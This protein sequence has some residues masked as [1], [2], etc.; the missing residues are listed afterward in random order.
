[1]R[2]ISQIN[3]GYLLPRVFTYNKSDDFGVV[4]SGSENVYEPLLSK[5][6]TIYL[7]IS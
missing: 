4:K 6:R 1:M 2:N 5:N 3:G 7:F